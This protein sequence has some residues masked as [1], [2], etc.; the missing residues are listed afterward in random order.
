MFFFFF[1]ITFNKTK[2]NAEFITTKMTLPL[3]KK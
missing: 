2:K 3:I 1:L